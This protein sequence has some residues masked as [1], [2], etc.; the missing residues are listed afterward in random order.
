MDLAAVIEKTRRDLLELTARNRLVH[1]PLDG[2]RK[3]WIQVHDERS[4]N[5]FDLLV[6]QGKTMSFLPV[7]SEEN[8]DD[9]E[10]FLREFEETNDDQLDDDSE[11][12][13]EDGELP[14]RYTDLFLQ[15]K[16]SQ[17][18]LNDRLLKLY[19]EA[20][21][22]EE[23]QGVSI[24]YLA[25]GFLKWR[26]SGSSAV[27]RY[28]PL[29][30]IPVEL[31]RNSV[32]SKF[33][34]NFRDDEIVTNLSIQA[35]L[36]Q[37]FGVRLPDLPEDIQDESPWTP[38]AYFDEIR[39]LIEG[40][41]GWEVLDNEILLWFF[42][43]TKFLMFRDLSPA[44]WPEG[45]GLTENG[46]IAGLLGDAFASG[47]ALPPICGDDEPID[48]MINPADVVHVTD[49]DSSQAVVIEEIV[50][51]RNLV[52]Q[53]PPG[54]GKSQTITNAIA[55]AV[56]AGKRVLF[57]A[58][59]MAALDVV[60]RR[61]DAVG[62]GPMSLELHSHKARKS[63]VLEDLKATMNL[64]APTAGN[65]VPTDELRQTVERLRHHDVT[66]HGQVGESGCS[67]FQ[68][69]GS[70]LNLRQ[71][72][73]AAAA[74]RVAEMSQWTPEAYQRCRQVAK[75]LDQLL[76]ASGT[77]ASNP[78][79][80]AQCK[81]M[82]PANVE[83]LL[84]TLKDV[85]DAVDKLD[86]A[87]GAL[88][89]ILEL[90]AAKDIKET[91]ELA[92]LAA[93]VRR[94]PAMV[95]R[96]AIGHESWQTEIERLEAI[97]KEVRTLQE[98]RRSLD[99]QISDAAWNLD[100]SAIRIALAGHGK[101]WFRIFN[102]SFRSAVA[103]LRG[104]CLSEFP[105]NA[106]ERVAL[107][108]RILSIQKSVKQ[109]GD[110]ELLC[111][112]V[113][114][115]V[116]SGTDSPIDD[117]DTIVAWVKDGHKA[118]LLR[119]HG[120]R[121]AED[122]TRGRAL[123]EPLNRIAKLLKTVDGELGKVASVLKIDFRRA[124]ETQ[125]ARTTSLADWRARMD[126]WQGASEQLSHY[127]A[128][129]ARVKTLQDAGLRELV[130]EIERGTL[131]AGDVA[132][133][134]ELIRS[135]AILA[136][137]WSDRRDLAEFHGDT[138]EKLRSRFAELDTDRI[139]QSRVDVA[140]KHHENLP[141]R[142]A[143]GGQ[144]S[145]VMRE[146][147]KKRRHMPIR[148]LI[149]E[150]GH[151]IQRIKPVFM[152]SPLSV[153]Q[154]LEPGAVEFDLLVIDE[155][156]QVQPVD[157][158]GAIA[159]SKQIVVVGDQRQLP[160]TDFFGRMS[161][162]QPDDDDDAVT[163]A[164]DLESILGLC[165]AQGLPSRMLSWHYRSRHESLIAVS[166]RQ[167]YDDRL[168]IVPS[169]VLSGGSLGLKLRYIADGCYDR[170]GSRANRNEAIAVAEAVLEHAR[171]RPHLSLGVATFSAAQRDA[172]RNEIELRR[173]EDASIEEF[174]NSGGAEPFFVK[175]LENVQGD[176]RDVIFISIGYGKDK[177]GYFAHSFGPL[178]R[179]GGERRLNVLI[180]RAAS[181]C[182]VFTSLKA[183]DID[184]AHTQSEGVA[185]LK[186][187]LNYAEHGRLDA[188]QSHG[189]ADSIFEEQVAKALRNR[190]LEVD[191]QIGVGGFF[192]DLAIRDPERRGRYLLGI[193]CDGAQYHSARWVRDRDRIRQQVLEARGWIIHRIWSTD[194]FQ[195]PEEQIEKTLEALEEAKRHWEQQDAED[196]NGACRSATPSTTPDADD[197]PPIS[198][199]ELPEA[200]TACELKGEDYRETR[201]PNQHFEGGPAEFADSVLTAFARQI[202]EIES[203]IHIDEIGRRMIR[204]C[205]QGRLVSSLKSRIAD[206]VTVLQEAGTVEQRDAFVYA[207]GQ[208]QFPVRYRKHLDNA[209]LRNIDFVPPE[210][211]RGAI[212]AVVEHQIGTDEKET[213]ASVAK[214]LGI[215]KSKSLQAHVQKQI[216]RLVEMHAI[217][218]R[219]GSLFVASGAVNQQQVSS[220]V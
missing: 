91:A 189:G 4:D 77:P 216:K 20:R 139:A 163:N 76:L 25:C 110:E 100:W 93:Y 130:N 187:Y 191:H 137:A 15:T 199:E 1:T 96:E 70:L 67:P 201:M 90:P 104:V 146:T 56:H 161:D 142:S 194:W 95:D 68:A 72:G 41:D 87:N 190:G 17:D 49:A 78:W 173:K 143:D 109:V 85:R 145:V 57:V 157:A 159:R 62:L 35:R 2:K 108:D 42:S 50:R 170:G 177:D 121:L 51:G 101:S 3:S 206:S 138:Y 176:Q 102:S 66:L 103:T 181:A 12:S 79:R 47:S 30:L 8:E 97:V 182:E 196:R 195:R 128:A 118:S 69:M 45:A 178:N 71:Q 180:S 127:L 19:Y 74:Y 164:S 132:E 29:L 43:F 214:L 156:S 172:I 61:L 88:A 81:P 114:G 122:A 175:S 111:R 217:E 185:A 26:E 220:R 211:L 80:G 13:G 134:L 131:V 92:Q 18:A 171:Q 9:R 212:F 39:K 6:R 183:D 125:D 153:A 218:N 84:G 59:K 141:A 55:A 149:K 44:A 82:T 27:D 210:E 126:E 160:P 152:M 46:L 113:F 188:T 37:D 136:E 117:L 38:T 112:S 63:E 148:R 40:R 140:K 209:K 166:N 133:Q 7:S 94:C 197:H 213:A 215:S 151:A 11:C 204:I 31:S 52:V 99:G 64:G 200:M 124:F 115:R 219:D 193:E 147:N 179:K 58:E 162:G 135:D 60:K 168:F 116:W 154:Y 119:Q 98:S 207:A 192:I 16:F 165:E 184:L 32:R 144:V 65:H 75:E 83:R 169:P 186:M 21:T 150:A 107:V 53:G 208:Q 205:G 105:K 155:A 158:L 203:P 10:Q 86:A 198:R 73:R 24:L 34:V 120:R 167:F 33:R 48:Q 129:M 22:A 23:E 5:V 36:Q 89:E 28:A 174:F 54:T 123:A 106:D 202:I 14:E